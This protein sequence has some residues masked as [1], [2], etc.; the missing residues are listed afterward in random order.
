MTSWRYTAAGWRLDSSFIKG[1]GP[2]FQGRFKVIRL[3]RIDGE[4]NF[5]IGTV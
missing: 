4:T 1:H 3:S 2:G 5:R